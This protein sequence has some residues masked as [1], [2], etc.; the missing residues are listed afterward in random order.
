VSTKSFMAKVQADSTNTWT[1]NALRFA[2]AEEA[3]AYGSNL[4]DRW[5]AVRAVCIAPSDDEVNYCWNFASHRAYPL[6]ESDN[7]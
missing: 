2:T 1:S 3:H 7:G 5:S 4:E 6:K